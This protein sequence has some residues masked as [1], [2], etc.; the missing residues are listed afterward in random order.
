[1]LRTLA[2]YC[3][4]L[5]AVPVV[6]R[7]LE[8]NSSVAEMPMW[9]VIIAS[10]LFLIGG[11]LLMTLANF[12]EQARRDK[13]ASALFSSL[14]ESQPTEDHVVPFALYLRPFATTGRLI[15]TNPKRRWLPILPSYFEH[16]ETLEFETLLS[17]ALAPDLPLIALG[18]PGE[19]VGAGR[20]AVRDED[21]RKVFLQLIGSARWILMIPNDE[22]ETRWEVEQLVTQGYL[23]KTLFIMPPKL[24]SKELDVTEY[25]QKAVS[26]LESL[27]IQLPQYNAAGQLFRLGRAGQ[28]Y[29]G[30]Y[31]A[32]LTAPILRDRIAGLTTRPGVREN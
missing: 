13:R 27:S 8:R 5:A 22:G 2:Y 10:A 28:Y 4:I 25:W 19:H 26:G 21:W 11:R 1:M 16:E 29:R 3:Y 23:H 12:R 17:E 18:K 31:L 30:R 20:L 7:L 14:I 32:K 15:V 24:R 9:A 6:L